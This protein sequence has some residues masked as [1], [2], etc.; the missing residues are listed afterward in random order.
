MC[1]CYCTAVV[2]PLL[3]LKEP[4][5]LLQDREPADQQDYYRDDDDRVSVNE[6]DEEETNTTGKFLSQ[7][8][9]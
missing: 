4:E 3:Q 8:H 6:P 7:L 9:S 2:Q 5:L 1:C